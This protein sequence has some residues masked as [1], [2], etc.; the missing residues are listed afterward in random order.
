M[1]KTTTAW[2]RGLTLL[3]GAAAAFSVVTAVSAVGTDTLPVPVAAQLSDNHLPVVNITINETAEGFGTID[4]MNNS[5]DH[6]V[7]CT[8]TVQIDVPEGYTGDYSNTVLTDTEKLPLEYIRGR[9]N[10][11]WKSDK[12]PYKLKLDKKAD[13][14]G[15][16]KNKHWALLA[17]NSDTTLLRNRLMSYIG[18]Q[19]GMPYTPKMLPVDVVMNGEYLGSYC[20]SELVRVDK[21]RVNIDEMTAEDNE[22]P[23]V[24][25]G[26]LLALSLGKTSSDNVLVTDNKVTFQFESPQFASEDPADTLGTAEQKAYITDYLRR[27]ENA[28]YG[29]GFV[30][31]NGETVEELL[32]LTSA[33]D[34]WW[35]QEFSV[36]VDAFR[37][38]SNYLYKP[39]GEKLY[40]GPLWDFDLTFGVSTAGTEGFNH[41]VMPWL[42]ELRENNPSFQRLLK[43]RWQVLS[44]II[45]NIVKKGGVL[46]QYIAEVR[47]SW[48]DNLP[49]S[50][51]PYNTMDREMDR[52]RE[53]LT[54]RQAWINENLDS[55]S[56]VY[57]TVTFMADD[58]T[59][60]TVKL[61]TGKMLNE[62]PNAPQKDGQVFLGWQY[63]D[64]LLDKLSLPTIWQDTVIHA[65]YISEDEA[66]KTEH[67]YFY[68]YDVWI[69]KN[70][71]QFTPT[72]VLAPFDAQDR[73]L[74]WASSDPSVAEVTD[75]GT[76]LL[77]A[78]GTVT[79]TAATQFG[80]SN[81][82]TLHVYDSTVTP[83][84]QAVD[85]T[86][87]QP[88][89]M[90]K[91]GEYAQIIAR[92]T[93]QPTYD[94]AYFY[95]ET[96][97]EDEEAVV[98]LGNAGVLQALR[99]G[100]AEIKVYCSDDLSMA[101]TVTVTDK[102]EPSPSSDVSEP[103]EGSEPF[104]PSDPSESSDSSDPSEPSESS[105]DKT[106][107]LSRS[108]S[109]EEP[110]CA[111]SSESR[112]DISSG[113][114]TVRTGDHRIAVIVLSVMALTLSVIVLVTK[115]KR[116]QA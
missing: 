46:D 104:A 4:E 27:I 82:Y 98:T 109:S 63:E 61:Y 38:D 11:T 10:T 116:H 7:K 93:P 72:Y 41:S 80:V 53:W 35:V 18:T 115:G 20:L 95:L 2:Q 65:V 59:V 47:Y 84:R 68:G 74:Q 57:S 83:V 62:L 8:G 28:V 110:S 12:K 43:E 23:A 32:D 79:I 36:N 51:D 58:Q 87:E 52:L 56:N 99:P 25:G 77:K 101:V 44:G 107:D 50:K 103:S 15:M 67:I 13:L 30:N 5:P 21:T 70:W 48:E 75:S 29:T 42:D 60:K 55:V 88:H 6:S 111:S 94:N 91:V 17:N 114:E 16:G 49:L 66:V 81:T 112:T 54:T 100:T 31:E 113:E 3:L 40:F 85:L 78:A 34:F 26:Y 97:A 24:S 90:M 96:D 1:T 71:Y 105:A 108:E 64:E 33:A 73:F 76:V 22:E 106:S 92:V 19:L 89:L 86:V 69:D 9:G 45:D 102:D 14:L 39:R 37:T